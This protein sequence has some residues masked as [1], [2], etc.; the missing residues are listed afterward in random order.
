[1]EL[2]E[3][4]KTPIAGDQPAGTDA[5]YEPEYEQLQAEVG[6]LTNPSSSGGVNW[7]EVEKISTGILAEKSKD[8]L[9]ASYLVVALLHN[10]KLEGLIKG[11]AFLKDFLETFWEDLYPAKKR[12]RGRKNAIEWFYDQTV[13]YME[14][15]QAQPVPEEKYNALMGD[16]EAVDNFL[17]EK[18]EEDPPSGREAREALGMIP[19]QKKDQPPPTAEG[20]ATRPG[21]AAAP[22][23]ITEIESPQDAQKVI[24]QAM[25]QLKMAA[26]YYLENDPKN[27]LAYT[28][29]R[30]AAWMPIENLPPLAEGATRIPPPVDQ[31][32][33]VLDNLYSA[34]DWENLLTAAETKVNQFLFWLDLSR[35]VHE[36]LGQLGE[37]YEA[38]QAAVAKETAAF[39]A[40][41]KG[42]ETYAFAD[43]TPFADPATRAWLAQI[44]SAGAG[45]G[46][47]PMAQAA[48][49]DSEDAEIEEQYQNAVKMAKKRKL[50]EAV[51]ML[52]DGLMAGGSGKARMKWRIALAE[53]L[54]AA[55]KIQTATP[56]LE[57]ILV[58]IEKHDLM[59]WDPQ[60]ALQGLK[61]ALTGFRSGKDEKSLER[62][63]RVLESIARVDPG[64]AL[65][66]E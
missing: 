48:I 37:G 26:N 47:Q 25:K 51:E 60:L 20:A 4:G 17:Q 9:V 12:M 44:A 58:D 43:Q 13:A 53:L 42:I 14:G 49:A 7:G 66:L 62:A 28:I 35:M 8:I 41:L 64:E 31:I 18:M 57:Q 38:A 32:K 45:E 27:P 23:E 3:I 40:R 6:K 29:N 11:I 22:A 36:A 54:L 30:M 39:V 10:Q 24:N 52:K 33:S 16:F 65:K 46:A 21:A 19:V 50:P 2:T 59:E 5:R 55:R 1:M 61:S 63:A 56:H 15:F 34:G